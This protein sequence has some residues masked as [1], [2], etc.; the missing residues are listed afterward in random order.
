MKFYV[1]F[2]LNTRVANYR[3]PFPSSAQEKED[4]HN[5]LFSKSKKALV[6]SSSVPFLE[7]FISRAN[8][9]HNS[10]LVL[11]ETNNDDGTSEVSFI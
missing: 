4:L 2:D 1:D 6:L 5:I 7:G 9:I 8:E 3:F 11:T 10:N